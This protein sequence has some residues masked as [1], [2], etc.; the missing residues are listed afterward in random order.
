MNRNAKNRIISGAFVLLAAGAAVKIL[1]LV[2]KIPL[3]YMIGDTGMGYFNVAYNIYAWFYIISTAGLPVSVSISVAKASANS[4]HVKCKAIFRYAAIIFSSF[5]LLCSALMMIFSAPLAVASSVT[6]SKLCI[7][8]V[9]PS[10]FFGC[11]SSSVRGYYQGKGIMWP[12]AVS[13]VAEAAGKICFGLIFASASSNLQPN[14]TAAYTITGVTCGS[15]LSAAICVIIKIFYK[16][17]KTKKTYLSAA[18]RKNVI[19]ELLKTALPVTVSSSVMNLTGLTDVFA[20]PSRL[21][22]IGYTELQ[23]TEIFGNYTTL[24]VP[25]MNLPMIFVYPVTSAVLPV[26]SA[27]YSKDEKERVKNVTGMLYK[28]VLALSLPCA[29][30]MSV[31]AAPILSLI[32]PVNSALLASPMLTVLAPAS[33]FCAMLAATDTVL[34]AKGKAHFTII[35][36]LAGSAVKF[37][38]TSLLITVIGRIAIPTGTCLCYMTA[39]LLNL[40]FLCEKNSF[41]GLKPIVKLS[42]SC[43]L[44][45]VTAYYVYELLHIEFN[46]ALSCAVSVPV[47]AAVYFAAL[48]LTGFIDKKTIDNIIGKIKKKELHHDRI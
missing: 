41:L 4:D 15:A 12:T 34:S 32:F 28:N 39:V 40:I 18:Y 45:G 48:Y 2:F 25:M 33:A 44:C 9:A 27:L 21:M 43:A 13:Q 46:N 37:V 11:I 35:S 3:Q 20:A 7:A 16:R 38:S 30:G 24:A 42:L 1:G 14:I 36:M 6:G 31:L 8:A 5:G 10:V 22:K 47:A 29:V 19:K 26:I 23:S 17:T